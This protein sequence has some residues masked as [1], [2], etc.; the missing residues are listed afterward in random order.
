MKYEA[1]LSA[2]QHTART[3]VYT[4]CI[5]F[6]SFREIRW[7]GMQW[8]DLFAIIKIKSKIW[9]PHPTTSMPMP[10]M[11]TTNHASF[12]TKTVTQ[13]NDKGKMGYW[14]SFISFSWQ[15]VTFLLKHWQTQL[16]LLR[17]F[18]MHFSCDA[19]SYTLSRSFCLPLCLKYATQV[20]RVQTVLNH[21]FCW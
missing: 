10:G 16:S 20:Q 17:M 15:F 11:L 3:Q 19:W 5:R 14:L 13:I 18:R 2:L 9:Y 7:P 21:D 12:I 4:Q 8:C 1:W 6:E